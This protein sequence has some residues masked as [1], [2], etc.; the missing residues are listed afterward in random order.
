VDTLGTGASYKPIGIYFQVVDAAD[1]T[2]PDLGIGVGV[3]S[4]P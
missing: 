3:C 2:L 1:V 4:G